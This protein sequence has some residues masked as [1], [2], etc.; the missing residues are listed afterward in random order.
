MEKNAVAEEFSKH[1]LNGE[2]VPEDVLTLLAHAEQLAERT[3]IQLNW[4]PPWNPW[5][6]TSYLSDADRANP[7][8]MANVRAIREVCELIAFIAADEDD[9]YFGYWRSP[10]QGQWPIHRLCVLTT[11]GNL[12]SAAV[13]SSQRRCWGRCT[14]TRSSRNSGT[15]CGPSALLSARKRRVNSLIQMAGILQTICTRNCT[16]AT[17]K[18]RASTD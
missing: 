1:R 6:D 9:Q 12:S 4:Q 2:P 7:D 15:G 16:I 5:L 11:R 8:I 10:N 3:T 17:G 13:P 18:R 14:A